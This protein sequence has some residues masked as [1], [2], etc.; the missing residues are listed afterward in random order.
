MFMSVYIYI[1]IPMYMYIWIYICMCIHVCKY[2]YMYRY[3]D[4]CEGPGRYVQGTVHTAD[5]FLGASATRAL[6]VVAS[7]FPSRWGTVHGFVHTLAWCSGLMVSHILNIAIASETSN[8]P[9]HDLGN[10]SSLCRGALFSPQCA[11]AT[12]D[13]RHQGPWYSSSSQNARIPNPGTQRSG[14][15]AACRREAK[16]PRPSKPPP[17]EL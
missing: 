11:W 16:H 6:R 7:A 4:T 12:A 10:S 9:Q 8:T 14:L 15:S 1:Y 13:C 5:S 3:M 2:I 17:L